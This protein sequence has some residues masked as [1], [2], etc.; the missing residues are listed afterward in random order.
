MVHFKEDTFYLSNFTS[1]K[2]I[3]VLAD[4]NTLLLNKKEHLAGAKYSLN[5]KN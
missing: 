5:Q 1:G 3:E 2:T 4:R